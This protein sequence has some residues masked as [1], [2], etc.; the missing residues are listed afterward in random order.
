[1]HI[2]FFFKFI[3]LLIGCAHLSGTLH[4]LEPWNQTGN[5]YLH[6]LFHSHFPMVMILVFYNSNLE[7]LR[8][9]RVLCHQKEW[10]WLMLKFWTTWMVCMVSNWRHWI[11]FENFKYHMMMPLWIC[12]SA[13][14]V[15][16]KQFAKHRYAL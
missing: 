14:G 8:L 3:S 10:I 6:F 4:L 2:L 12:C 7:R 16:H 1:M 9:M 15:P 11:G 5:H 13:F